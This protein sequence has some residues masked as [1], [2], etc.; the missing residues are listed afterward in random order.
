MSFLTPD[1]VSRIYS[2]RIFDI[3]G[4]NHRRRS[5]VCPLPMHDHQNYTPSFAIYWSGDRWRWQCFGNCNKYGDVIDLVGYMNVPLYDPRD[6]QKLSKAISILTGENYTPSAPKAPEKVQSDNIPRNVWDL[7]RI[8]SPE[9]IRYGERRG[10]LEGTLRSFHIG[11]KHETGPERTYMAIPTF[12]DRQLIGI[13]LRNIGEGPRYRA[14]KGSR[15]GLFNYDQVAYVQDRVYVVKGEIAA[16][17]LIQNGLLSCAPTGGESMKLNKRYQTAL[18][19]ADVVVIGDNDRDPEVRKQTTALA[20][21]RAETL[22]AK[23]IF[24]PEEYKDVDEWVLRDFKAIE[25]LK[26]V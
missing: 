14:V 13:K 17:V 19:L 23:L 2:E 12:K 16:L 26:E 5:I 9:V 20:E 8:L 24:P 25:K 4:T 21:E 3:T 6:A 1:E 15:S 11:S 22:H 7:Y 18:A 10:L